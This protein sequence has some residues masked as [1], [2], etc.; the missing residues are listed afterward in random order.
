MDREAELILMDEDVSTCLVAFEQGRRFF[1]LVA[2]V[3]MPVTAYSLRVQLDLWDMSCTDPGLAVYEKLPVVDSAIKYIQCSSE[4]HT[5][6]NDKLTR[7]VYVCSHIHSWDSVIEITVRLE[8][9]AF[10]PAGG[11]KVCEFKILDV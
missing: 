8:K 3:Y 2:F 7:C 6:S 11:V 9:L 10:G 1:R 4:K 5:D